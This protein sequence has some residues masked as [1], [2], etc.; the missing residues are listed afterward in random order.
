MIKKQAQFQILQ[1][2]ID[3]YWISSKLQKTFYADDPLFADAKDLTDYQN[4]I[5]EHLLYNM[6]YNCELDEEMS[7]Y[8]LRATDMEAANY[9]SKVFLPK[10]KIQYLK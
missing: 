6:D 1:V 8:M 4:A 5:F 2:L 3:G 9:Y 10:F 7:S